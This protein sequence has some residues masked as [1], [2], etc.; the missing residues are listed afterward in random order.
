MSQETENGTKSFGVLITEAIADIQVLVRQSI[1]LAVLELKESG[2]RA[3]MASLLVVIAITLFLVSGLLLVIALAFGFIALG[4]PAWL[5]FVVDA[6]LFIAA[7][8]VLL[9]IAKS[10]AEKVK[11]PTNA[12]DS[13]ETSINTITATVTKYSDSI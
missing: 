6:L 5:A 10:N 2:R 8:G 9:L 3:L 7:G 11:A 4:L 13:I 1:Q 12:A